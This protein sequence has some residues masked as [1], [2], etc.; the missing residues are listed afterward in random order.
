MIKFWLGKGQVWLEFNWVVRGLSYM[1]K[2]AKRVETEIMFAKLVTNREL[3][4][5]IKLELS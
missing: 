1:Y 2:Q 4:L 5:N 3:T